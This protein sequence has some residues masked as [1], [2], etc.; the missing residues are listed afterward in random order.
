MANAFGVAKAE[1]LAGRH[2][3]LVDDV[4]TTGATT[5]HCVQ[6]LVD[7]CPNVRVSVAALAFASGS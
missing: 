5:E 4:M 2:V 3:L 6:A 1:L 7:A